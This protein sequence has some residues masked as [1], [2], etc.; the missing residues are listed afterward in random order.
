MNSYRLLTTKSSA[1][2]E[3]RAFE[4]KEKAPEAERALGALLVGG[5]SMLQAGFIEQGND[6][7]HCSVI[8]AYRKENDTLKRVFRH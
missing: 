6:F 4:G 2:E 5:E 3:G 1:A 8:R 7:G